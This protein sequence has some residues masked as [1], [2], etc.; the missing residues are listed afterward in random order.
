[1][2]KRKISDLFKNIAPQIPAHRQKLIKNYCLMD[3]I[4][5]P[6]QPKGKLQTLF[7]SINN[8]IQNLRPCPNV[9]V[10]ILKKHLHNII[11]IVGREQR[12]GAYPI[13]NNASIKSVIGNDVEWFLEQWFNRAII[14][15][16]LKPRDELWWASLLD[17]EIIAPSTAFNGIVS[18]LMFS[19][20]RV[21]INRPML[22]IP[23]CS[24]KDYYNIVGERHK[25][26]IPHFIF[27]QKL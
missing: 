9:N 26:N 6:N 14:L 13:I 18:H 4:I 22:I 24:I 8:F 10:D 15:F 5:M 2:R 23:S 17:L 21:M 20:M 27:K 19:T 3:G 11:Q 12:T 25:T 16:S 1:M 7:L